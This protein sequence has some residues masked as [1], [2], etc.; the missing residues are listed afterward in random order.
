[1]DEQEGGN[2]GPYVSK[3]VFNETIKHIEEEQ[4]LHKAALFGEDGR[5]G[6]CRDVGDVLHL[7]KTYGAALTICAGIISP[8]IVTFLLRWL[9]I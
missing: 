9:G 3:A 5:G 8:I 2:G 1:M 7:F 4:L 6:L